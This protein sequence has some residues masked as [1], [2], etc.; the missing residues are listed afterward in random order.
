MPP[1][2]AAQPALQYNSFI[3]LLWL[4]AVYI[5]LIKGKPLGGKRLM[6]YGTSAVI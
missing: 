4:T 1:Y 2:K 6:G 5:L 3:I